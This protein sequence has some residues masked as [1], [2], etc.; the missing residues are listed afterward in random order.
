VF[1]TAP[2]ILSILFVTEVNLSQ[3]LSRIWPTPPRLLL[4]FSLGHCVADGH[5]FLDGDD[6]RK[7]E[8]APCFGVQRAALTVFS[9]GVVGGA[10]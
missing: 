7:S 5:G 4:P 8:G 6:S 3:E 10:G 1:S 9:H 2:A